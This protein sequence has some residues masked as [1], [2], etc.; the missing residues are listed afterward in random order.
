MPIDT[1]VRNG[2][3][4]TAAGITGPDMGVAIDD[5]TIVAVGDD[6]QLPA[7]T[8]TID[9]D[10][11]LIVPGL[12]DGHVHNRS[13]GLEYKEDWY[14]ATC[15][16]AAGG[17]TTVIGMP[18]TDPVVDDVDALA[19]KY[20]LGRESA[21][22]DIQTVAMVT[23]ENREQ[24]AP[25]VEHGVAGFLVSL[26]GPSP[27]DGA[28]LD[29][30]HEIARTEARLGVHSEVHGIVDHYTNRCQD[31]GDVHP[32]YQGRAR[33]PIAE[34]EG[35]SRA[36]RYAKETACPIH[37]FQV[38]TGTGAERIAAAKRDGVD[39]TA[40][41]TPHYLWFTDDVY[42]RKGTLAHIWP[43]IRSR[44][45]RDRLW[46]AGVDGGAIDSIATDHSPHTDAEKRLDDPFGNAFDALPG[47]VGLE[48]AAP[49]MLTYVDSGRLSVERWVRMHSVRPAQ[50]WGLYPNKG[51]LEIGT[52]ADL[53]IVDPTVE[54]RFDRA[55]LHSKNTASPFDGETFVGKPTKTIVRGEL[56]YDGTILVEPGH[57]TVVG[58]DGR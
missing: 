52:D 15:A 28:V 1:L 22:V 21:V 20:E 31:A 10:G 57:G 16:A 9:A 3:L 2:T 12:V 8:E 44:A 46:S 58:V 42:D 19:L 25:L 43:P 37:V 23:G 26:A 39:V 50:I 33:P 38:S 55:E 30:M 32:R 34:V 47:F 35:I 18:N 48:S 29:A 45:E 7:A 5:G 49:A 54:F 56:V 13:P 41:T 14:T 40:E 4:V 6:R 27:T 17:V 51:S 36:M 11:G 24:L 53:T